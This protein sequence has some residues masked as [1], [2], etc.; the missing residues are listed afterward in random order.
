MTDFIAHRINTIAELKNLPSYFGA[1]LDLRDDLNGRI[2]IQHNPFESGDD[3]EDFLKEYHH[4]IMI[5]NIK[6]ERIELNCLKL[7]AKFN[8]K[9]Y[10]FLDSTFPMIWLLSHQG[11]KN[12]ALR[13]SEVEG[14]D[15]AINMAG[16]ID[17]IWVDCFSRIPIGHKEY[18]EL[19]NLGY[20][21]CFVSPELENRDWDIE[22][23]AKIIKRE[24]IIFDAICTKQHNICRWKKLLSE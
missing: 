21:L 2:Y 10:F 22:T 8:I 13:I 23:Y 5:L 9:N 20:K 18:K 11:E 19:K 17:W 14:L 6:S 12:I 1:E 16:K 3:F 24:G 4:G 7:L 15:T